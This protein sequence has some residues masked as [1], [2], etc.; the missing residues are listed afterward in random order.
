MKRL[1]TILEEEF[2]ER[3][4]RRMEKRVK[5][6]H[7]R[8]CA[9]H[10]LARIL[11]KALDIN[12]KEL[13]KDTKFL[14]NLRESGLKLRDG[15]EWSGPPKR[16]LERREKGRSTDIFKRF[17]RLNILNLLNL[18]ALQAELIVLEDAYSIK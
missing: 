3:L 13:E 6:D 12:Y 15:E 9:A 4:G 7:Y 17:G 8:V 18:L 16:L 11:E 5:T 1:D 10:D 14:N 2:D